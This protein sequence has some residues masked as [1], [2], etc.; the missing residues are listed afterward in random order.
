MAQRR[1]LLNRRP[2]KTFGFR[3]RDLDYTATTGRFPEGRLAEIFLSGGWMNTVSDAIAR[4][5]GVVAGAQQDR[6][7]LSPQRPEDHLCLRR[8][9]QLP[10][11]LAR[12]AV[13][14]PRSNKP[15]LPASA[16]TGAGHFLVHVEI[17]ER[18]ILI[19]PSR[20]IEVGGQAHTI[21]QTGPQQWDVLCFETPEKA[22]EVITKAN[23]AIDR[24]RDV[25]G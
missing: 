22:H 21:V 3:W 2:S 15:R 8:R 9:R 16:R 19:L 23:V 24:D 6:H 20:E 10:A 12:G 13:F 7:P 1:R 17:G 5:G 11:S 4:D 14:Q 18:K 25:S